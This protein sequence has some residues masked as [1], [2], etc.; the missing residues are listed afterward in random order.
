MAEARRVAELELI[1]KSLATPSA[2]L[3]PSA[4][5]STWTAAAVPPAFRG[6]ALPWNARR[7]AADPLFS[8][9]QI[10]ERRPS[11]RGVAP[12]PLLGS[13]PGWYD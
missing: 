2:E 7:R 8:Q 9:Q 5:S 3:A 12:W 1:K 6:A 11:G 13:A 4:S 10:I